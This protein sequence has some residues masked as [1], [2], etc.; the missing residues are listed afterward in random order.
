MDAGG[1]ERDHAEHG[2]GQRVDIVADRQLELAE[3][4]E[5][6]PVAADGARRFGPRS[7]ERM[8]AEPADQGREGKQ[9][10]PTIAPVAT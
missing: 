10:P 8:D 7:R 9:K 4:A 3:L 5:R 1:D 6:V 2:D